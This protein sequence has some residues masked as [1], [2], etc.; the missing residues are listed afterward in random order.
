MLDDHLQSWSPRLFLTYIFL[1]CG[2]SGSREC[3]IASAKNRIPDVE[4]TFAFSI[5]RGVVCSWLYLFFAFSIKSGGIK[6][7]KPNIFNTIETVVNVKIKLNKS[8]EK[9]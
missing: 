5:Q 4:K 2:F 3:L 7:I 6:L 8:M 9:S 1:L